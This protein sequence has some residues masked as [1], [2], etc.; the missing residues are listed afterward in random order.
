MAVPPLLILVRHARA[1]PLAE[2]GAGANMHRQLT[3]LGHEQ[4]RRLAARLATELGARPVRLW[5]SDYVRCRATAAPLAAAFQ[6]EPVVDP[7]LRE[8]DAG[9]AT[10]LSHAER[11]ARF[12]DAFREPWGWDFRPFPGAETWREFYARC[13]A[14]L[15]ELPADG[16]L[17]VV[18]AHGSSIDCLVARWLQLSPEVFEGVTFAAGYASL[19]VVSSDGCDNRAI[20]RLNDIAHLAGADGWVGLGHL[21]G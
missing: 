8:H 5:T 15:D 17:P 16:P 12:P 18:V 20:E 1:L 11:I 14:F 10:D 4:A 6:V 9:E 21:A 19:S 7:R 13:C 2:S 3:S